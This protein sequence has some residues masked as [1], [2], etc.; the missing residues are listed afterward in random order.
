MERARRG[1]ELR[2]VEG[3]TRALFSW[4]S[5]SSS[6]STISSASPSA[7]KRSPLPRLLALCGLSTPPSSCSLDALPHTCEIGISTPS[8]NLIP[9]TVAHGTGGACWASHTLPPTEG[10]SILL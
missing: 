4:G 6:P 3:S 9:L 8:L 7:Y 10:T 5:R 2:T 1:V